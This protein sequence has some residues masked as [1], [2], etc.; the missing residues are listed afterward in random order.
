MESKEHSSQTVAPKSGDPDQLVIPK[1]C[2][3]FIA[4]L[5]SETNLMLISEPKVVVGRL[6]P[7]GDIDFP[8]S[9]NKMISHKHFVIEYIESEF[10]LVCLSKN[11][12][13]VNDMLVPKDANPYMLPKT[14][15]FRFPSTSIKLFF[16][17]LIRRKPHIGVL[18]DRQDLLTFMSNLAVQKTETNMGEF[19]IS[20]SNEHA[21]VLAESKIVS[22]FLMDML[23]QLVPMRNL[24]TEQVAI[25]REEADEPMVEGDVHETVS[26]TPP[27]DDVKPSFSYAQLIAEAIV[28]SPKQQLT[29]SE[30]YSYLMEKYPYFRMKPNGG[31]QNSIR[32]NLSLNQY[33]VKVPRTS[34]NVGKGCYW[35]IDP[36]VYCKAMA[37]R[38]QKN[39]HLMSKIILKRCMSKPASMN[40]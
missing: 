11:G 25:N 23:L 8:V 27:P 21:V 6:T 7:E 31:W 33:F 1:N 29:L 18:M 24:P 17:N 19:S 14:C 35:R 13:F 2:F 34:K 36:T 28:A 22:S 9:T 12:I 40:H 3:N 15:Y 26:E 32:H 20:T 10:W 4:N 16:N 38:P 37:N 5:I 39:K 30:I